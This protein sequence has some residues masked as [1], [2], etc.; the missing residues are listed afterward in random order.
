M[1]N[2][3][4]CAVLALLVSATCSCTD[5]VLTELRD[6]AIDGASSFVEQEVRDLLAQVF[7]RNPSN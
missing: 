5:R 7:E 4:V 6:A 3:I 2:R 1:R